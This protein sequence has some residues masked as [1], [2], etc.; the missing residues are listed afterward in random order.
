MGRGHEMFLCLA[1]GRRWK[2]G[3][4]YVLSFVAIIT[5]IPTGAF[6]F[7]VGCN[8]NILALLPQTVQW[9]KDDAM[10]FQAWKE[11]FPD[12]RAG[13]RRSW[14]VLPSPHM[15]VVQGG[16]QYVGRPSP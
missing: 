15:Q 14:R 10:G 7:L 6:F 5:Y 8:Q 9:Q 2:L 16:P 12:I 13:N 4:C 1:R 11:A 3:N